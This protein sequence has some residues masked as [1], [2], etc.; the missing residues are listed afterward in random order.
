MI[1]K[2]WEYE[3]VSEPLSVDELDDLGLCE[4][5]LCGFS[6]DPRMYIFRRLS[7]SNVI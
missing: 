7:N 3:I 1:L 2:Q 4:W 6:Y 5:I